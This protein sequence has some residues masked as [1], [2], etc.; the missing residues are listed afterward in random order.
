MPLSED[1]AAPQAVPPPLPHTLRFYWRQIIK[2]YCSISDVPVPPQVKPG[3]SRSALKSVAADLGV[4]LPGDKQL[5]SDFVSELK[6]RQSEMA[7]AQH[8]SEAEFRADAAMKLNGL[9]RD[10]SNVAAAAQANTARLVIVEQ[11]LGSFQ[12]TMN[13]LSTSVEELKKMLQAQSAA[14]QAQAAAAQPA[15]PAAPAAEP[16]DRI[17]INGG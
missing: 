13:N 11:T 2:L 14:A 1:Q 8:L 6:Q 3:I 9:H 7:D 10:I 12:Q 16:D 17:F 4:D 15:P 5:A